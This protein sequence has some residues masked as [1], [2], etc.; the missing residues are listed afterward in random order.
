MSD[1]QHNV[2]FFKQI[3]D[4]NPTQPKYYYYLGIALT[5][6]N[7][8]N[9][10]IEAYRKAIILEPNYAEAYY[11]LGI[12]LH[13]Q[14]QLDD[15]AQA[16]QQT[17]KVNPKYADAY[18]NL[19]A[20]RYQQNRLEEAVQAY[21]EL[22]LIDSNNLDAYYDLATIFRQQGKVEDLID[23]YESIL[24][25]K[26]EHTSIS[27]M[28]SVLKGEVEDE[29]PLV[30]IEKLFDGY[31][32]SYDQHMLGSL[33]CQIP[34][35]LR[36]EL[37]EI[38]DRVPFDNVI[39][40]GCGTGL[41]GQAFRDVSIRL[42]GVDI[43]SQM[44]EVAK[45]KNIYDYLENIDLITFLSNSRD[46]FDLFISA[47]VFGYIGDLD[48]IFKSVSATANEHALFL[49]SVEKYGQEEA[50]P[51]KLPYVVR[52]SGR[53]AHSRCYITDLIDQYQFSL[54]H[55]EEAIIR[56]DYDQPIIG[57]FYRLRKL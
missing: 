56:N 11:N 51:S 37:D 55:C 31:A 39:D 5:G 7:Q 35:L 18:H 33:E 25:I 53:V 21:Q 45:R 15:A 6:S 19:G 32:E 9:Q 12:I 44:I 41:S 29:V 8:L 3:I 28:V 46:K 47:D 2:D 38:I 20:L 50:S 1:L 36:R 27:Y 17:L 22:I 4:T 54:E 23:C 57:D 26:P 40:L 30:Y 43:S 24:R 10:A 49:F 13:K 48:L 16:Y 14:G 34:L 52:S 42:I